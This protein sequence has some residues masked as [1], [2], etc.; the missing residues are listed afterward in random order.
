M[1]TDLKTIPPAVFQKRREVIKRSFGYYCGH[2]GYV[3]FNFTFLWIFIYC[4]VCCMSA[5]CTQCHF[6]LCYLFIAMLSVYAYLLGKGGYVF[7]SYFPIFTYFILA[8]CG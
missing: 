4:D 3:K 8:L 7:G 5:L 6:V 2:F 1:V